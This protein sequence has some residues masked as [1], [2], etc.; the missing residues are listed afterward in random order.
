[1]IKEKKLQKQKKH[2]NIICNDFL[3]VMNMLENLDEMEFS[4]KVKFTNLT[5]EGINNLNK[6]E[7][8]EEDNKE[9]FPLK[10]PCLHSCM[11]S[12]YLP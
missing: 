12:L 3:N 9:L 7:E 10:S 2:K 5:K 11:K 4:R 8:M 1:M 6:S